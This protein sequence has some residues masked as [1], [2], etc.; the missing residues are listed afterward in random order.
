M[1]RGLW[2]DPIKVAKIERA[3]AFCVDVLGARVRLRGEVLGCVYAMLRL[4]DTRLIL[5]EGA[6]R[7]DRPVPDS[8]RTREATSARRRRGRWETAPVLGVPEASRPQFST[9]LS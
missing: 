9:F 7:G 3:I 2:N 8:E 5:F 6:S 4:G 1:V